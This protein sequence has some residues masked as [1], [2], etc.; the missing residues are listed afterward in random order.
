MSA[1][2]IHTDHHHAPDPIRRIPAPVRDS[3]TPEQVSAVS[4]A[5]GSSGRHPVDLRLTLPLPGRPVFFSVVAGRERRSE[6]RLAVERRQHPLH[7]FGNIVFMLSSLTGLYAIAL[8]AVLMM[9]SVLK[10]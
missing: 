2:D 9:G 6:G 7:T 1:Q 10:F 8:V 5:V 4:S 3:F